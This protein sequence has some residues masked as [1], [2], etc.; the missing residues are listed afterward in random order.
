MTTQ[1][2]TFTRLGTIRHTNVVTPVYVY[3]RNNVKVYM[4]KTRKEA[5]VRW[6]GKGRGGEGINGRLL[7]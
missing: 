6:R 3:V 4:E 2:E 5:T 1:R 7:S